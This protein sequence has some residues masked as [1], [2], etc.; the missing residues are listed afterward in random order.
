MSFEWQL[1]EETEPDQFNREPNRK[2]VKKRPWGLYAAGLILV[3]VVALYARW[4]I[5]RFDTETL[6]FLQATVDLQ[7]ESVYTQNGDLY[8]SNFSSRPTDNYDQMHPSQIAFWLSRPQIVDYEESNQEI[9]AIAEWKTSTGEIRHRNLFFDDFDGSVRLKAD[10]PL[11]WGKSV[12]VELD[13]GTLFIFERDEAFTAEI[14]ERLQPIIERHCVINDCTALNITISPFQVLPTEDFVFISPRI[15]GLT[16]RG[17]IPESYWRYFDSRA[18]DLLGETTI[19]FAIPEMLT[20]LF[21]QLVPEFEALYGIQVELIPFDPIMG[22][23]MDLLGSIDGMLVQPKLE[24][25]TSGA[26]LPIEFYAQGMHTG[27]H[28]SHWA[29]AWWN[30]HMWFLP[31]DGELLFISYDASYA[32]DAG[33]P[34]DPSSASW[35]WDEFSDI[36]SIYTD[37]GIRWGIASPDPSILLSRAYSSE[38][39][40]SQIDSGQRCL[41]GFELTIEGIENALTYYAEHS[42]Q[43][44]IPPA[45]TDEQQMIHFLT[46]SSISVGNTAMWVSKPG[47]LE[48]DRATRNA[49]VMPFPSSDSSPAISP[50]IPR[51]GVISSKSQSPIS[52]WTFINWLSYQPTN[53]SERRVPARHSTRWA[54]NF[55]DVLPQPLGALM[56]QHFETARGVRLGDQDY[57]RPAVLEAIAAGEVTPEQA[58]RSRPPIQWFGAFFEESQ[59]AN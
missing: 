7:V 57:F 25:V 3:L 12:A 56:E 9:W 52:T 27:I 34:H 23:Q 32:A 18:S 17:E 10:A 33:D 26:I 22:N 54:N 4:R 6:A 37:S 28:P 36:M 16:P 38:N 41:L 31:I 49:V 47:R 51:G 53:L 45:G 42:D 46:E 29:S 58:A 24:M 11:Y 55:W 21:N 13:R 48:H 30:D 8:F 15:H 43:I 19:R 1:E 2:P 14:Q 5:N 39:D 50:L 20:S 35:Q 44:S 40:C 59:Q